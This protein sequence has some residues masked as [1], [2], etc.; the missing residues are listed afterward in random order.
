M[1]T[2][3]SG[4]PGSGKSLHL[5]R[6]ILN[7]LKLGRDV[8]CNFPITFTEKEIKKGYNERF[9]YVLNQNYT[10][11][12]L[13]EHAIDRG[14]FDKKKESQCMC[15]YD[16]AGGK[17][18]TRDFSSK[19]RMEWIDFFSQ[20]RKCGFDFILVA[21][22]DRMIDRQIRTLF[23]TEKEHRKLNNFGP[24]AM[25]PFKYFVCIERWY[26]AKQK[27]DVEYFRYKKAIGARYDS[28]KMFD[29]FKLSPELL[30]KVKFREFYYTIK[31]SLSLFT[32]KEVFEKLPDDIKIELK[33]S[34][35]DIELFCS[36]YAE[37]NKPL[38][39]VFAGNES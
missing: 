38:E 3:Y 7:N 13:L 12:T 29:G 9:F 10:I 6:V 33:L 17:Y 37:F 25:L 31:D 36:Q 8:I 34:I 27:V 20:H 14:Y 23:E 26:V 16:E 30:K 1:I 35:N 39:S 15:I 28:M 11:N 32:P 19:D 18:N 21:Q 24:F 4:T 5:I 2:L 22:S